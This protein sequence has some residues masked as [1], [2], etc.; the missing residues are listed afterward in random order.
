MATIKLVE[1]QVDEISFVDAKLP[2]KKGSAKDGKFYNRYKY[3]GTV[4]TVDSDHPFCQA[5]EQGQIDSVKLS[6]GT[7]EIEI[8]DE[9]GDVTET[10]TV[11]SL[12]FDSFISFK[13][14]LNRAEHRAKV[15]RFKKIEESPVTAEL[16]QE[17]GF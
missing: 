13:Q 12:Q 11:D 17:L 5:F 3:E 14:T 15:S 7:R 6:K 1:E 4:F 16:L 10:K 2:Y 9:N 8:K